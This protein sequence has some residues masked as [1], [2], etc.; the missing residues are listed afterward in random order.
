MKS[1][2]I[3]AMF[4]VV[5][6]VGFAQELSKKLQTGSEV[7]TTEIAPG[8]YY[9]RDEAQVR[10]YPECAPSGVVG[11]VPCIKGGKVYQINPNAAQ[12]AKPELPKAST[13][14]KPDTKTPELTTEQ[15]LTLDNLIKDITIAQQAIQIA[16]TQRDNATKAAGELIQSFQRDGFTFDYQTKTY[17]LVKK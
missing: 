12:A 5:S 10:I 8:S 14:V 7:N 3:A 13:E 9:S 2:V 1:F 15:K 11:E 4:V 17:T 16:L 6:G